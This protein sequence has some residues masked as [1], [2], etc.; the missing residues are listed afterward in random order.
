MD[1]RQTPDNDEAHRIANEI[2]QYMYGEGLDI[3]TKRSVWKRWGVTD[4]NMM[5]RVGQVLSSELGIIAGRNPP[6][7]IRE[8]SLEAVS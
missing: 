2:S 1:E 5:M 8:E 4:R 7:Y 3:I 6:S